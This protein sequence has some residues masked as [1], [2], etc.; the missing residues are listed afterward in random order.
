[1]TNKNGTFLKDENEVD[2]VEMEALKSSVIDVVSDLCKKIY[3][4]SDKCNTR[5]CM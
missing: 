5:K 1:L 4:N 3:L 2:K